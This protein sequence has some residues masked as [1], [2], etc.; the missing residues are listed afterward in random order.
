MRSGVPLNLLM[1]FAL[2]GDVYHLRGSP[3]RTDIIP[4]FPDALRARLIV[5]P[6]AGGA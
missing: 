6:M 2:C 3:R 5:G 1:Y 4:S